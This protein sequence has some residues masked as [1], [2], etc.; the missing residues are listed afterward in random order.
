MAEFFEEAAARR[1]P[2]QGVSTD[3]QVQAVLADFCEKHSFAFAEF[4]NA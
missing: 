4:P 2:L 1:I 3:P